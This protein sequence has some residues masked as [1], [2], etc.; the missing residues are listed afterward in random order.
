M[1]VTCFSYLYL[2]FILQLLAV[3]HQCGMKPSRIQRYLGIRCVLGPRRQA[4]EIHDFI[5]R[6]TSGACSIDAAGVSFSAD[7]GGS[8]TSAYPAIAKFSRYDG[9]VYICGAS[10]S[11]PILGN[12]AVYHIGIYSYRKTSLEHCSL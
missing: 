4:P 8:L 3:G 1:L 11:T 6:Q 12:C 9:F 2:Y 7:R 5:R 10:A